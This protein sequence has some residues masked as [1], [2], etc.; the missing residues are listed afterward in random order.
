MQILVVEDQRQM[1]TMIRRMLQQMKSFERVDEAEDGEIA[2]Q[3]ISGN[4]YPE[5]YD[6]IL[7]DI[8]MPNLDGIGLLKRCRSHELYRFLPFIMISASSH[9]AVVTGAI[10]EWGANDFIIKPFSLELL[11]QR[12]LA[13]IKRAQSPEEALYRKAEQLFADGEVDDALKL[14]SRW[15]SENS[16]SRAKWLNL[17]GECLLEKGDAA[18]ASSSFE[19]AIGVSSIFITAYKNY[20][21]AH[22]QLGNT[23]KA[24]S[25]LKYV[26]G[27]SPTDTDRTIRLSRLLLDCGRGEEGKFYLDKLLKRCNGLEKQETFKIVAE[28]LVEAGLFDAAEKIY[29]T[30]LKHFPADIESTNRLGIALRQQG[31][32]KEAEHCYLSALKVH[33]SHPG[34]FHN[35]GILYLASND[36]QKARRCLE[37]ALDLDPDL[38][39]ARA[40]LEQLMRSQK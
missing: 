26:E 8:E 11:H 9:G 14:I 19:K 31:K 40:A 13:A 38:E 39:A 22:E 1:R 7:C 5:P 34:L 18:S 4:E 10:G 30:I 25:A 33:S 28:V 16:M 20:A 23:D 35:L 36:T 6:V 3:K 37:K 15:E 17:R 32:H 27:L 2:W 29:L 12:V 24:I 21:N